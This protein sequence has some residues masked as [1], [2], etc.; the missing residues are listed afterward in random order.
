MRRSPALVL[1]LVLLT[2]CAQVACKRD[3]APAANA[4]AVAAVTPTPNVEQLLGEIAKHDRE[5]IRQHPEQP[6]G[7][8][9]LANTYFA[10]GK[11]EEAAEQYREV[12]RLDPRD[13]AARFELGQSLLRLNRA[14]EA[15]A[16]FNEA[17]KLNPKM[18]EAHLE[19]G[20]ALRKLDRQQEAVASY[21]R[22]ASA[23]EQQIKSDP[24]QA[25]RLKTRLADAHFRAGNALD[26]L[27][28]WQESVKAYEQAARHNPRDPDAHFNLGYAHSRLEQFDA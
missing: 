10:A 12:V 5:E 14:D 17:L 8:Y 1:P 26:K 23:F 9:N 18:A 20:D 2:V 13:A 21:R 11:Y 22:A 16:S 19:L 25:E 3:A 27:G 15:V 28:R 6:T 24:K 7:Y 4:N